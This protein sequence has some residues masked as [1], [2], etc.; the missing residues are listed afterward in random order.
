[1]VWFE[2]R[3]G[4]RGGEFEE[5]VDRPAL[6]HPG[7]HREEDLRQEEEG[8]QLGTQQEVPPHFLIHNINPQILTD[9]YT[10]LITTYYPTL[11]FYIITHY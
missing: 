3:L 11:P 4:V 1:M 8:Q 7:L 10:P 6:Q 2:R 9:F 5:G